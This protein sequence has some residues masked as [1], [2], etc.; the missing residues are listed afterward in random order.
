MRLFSLF[1]F[2]HSHNA[3]KASRDICTVHA[4]DFIADDMA[5]NWFS[6]F[7]QW[8]FK[9]KDSPRSSRPVQLDDNQLRAL[10]KEP[11]HTARELAQKIARSQVIVT[12][13][14]HSKS[15]VRKHGA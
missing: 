15:K 12:R 3:A 9:L 2:N 11:R 13:H 10:A 1:A 4:D 7:K 6:R 8:K 5:Q 14:L